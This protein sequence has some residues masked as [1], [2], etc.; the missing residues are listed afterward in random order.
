MSESMARIW[1]FCCSLKLAI[2]LASLA[3]LLAMGGSLAIYSRPD[4]YSGID[5]MTL[6]DWWRQTGRSHISQ[7]WWLALTGAL[8]LALGLNTACCL[9]DW[10]ARLHRRWRK[11]G[12]YLIHAGFCLLVVGFVIGHT[13]GF[14]MDRVQ[15]FEN[16]LFPI[17]P[18][19]G[20]YLRLDAIEPVLDKSGRPLD[21]INRLALVR[22]EEE[23]ARTTAR[24]N[25]PL[26]YRGLV[27]VPV[28]FGRQASGF[29]IFHPEKGHL[30]L[31]AGT[32]L[33]FGSAQLSVLRF[34]PDVTEGSDGTIRRRG[35]R[36][37]NPAFLVRLDKPGRSWQGWYLPR[38]GLPY[39]LVEAGIRFWPT[40]PLFANYSVLTV[41]RDPGSRLAMAGGICLLAGSALAL[42][43]YYR[44]RRTGD[45][46]EIS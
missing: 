30:E 42:I 4:I 41:N 32:S 3:T 40:E 20:H 46:P 23:V 25:H 38:K 13:L 37:N 2:I 33:T 19:P 26:Q 35:S 44:K 43:S 12:E 1:R 22:G 28:S 15:I 27:A 39:P 9:A 17:G 31:S 24:I 6:A 29:R 7:T 45:R 16:Q 36:L 11:T 14:R 21:M 8:L 5:Q 10:L 34:W 18:W